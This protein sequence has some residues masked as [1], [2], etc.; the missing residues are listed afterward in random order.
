LANS[1]FIGQRRF[2]GQKA[3]ILL[4]IAAALTTIEFG[5]LIETDRSENL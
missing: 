3:L 4:K 2:I 1:L 5:E